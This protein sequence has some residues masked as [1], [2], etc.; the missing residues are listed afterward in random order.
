MNLTV[1]SLVQ[2]YLM[3]GH[4]HHSVEVW[5]VDKTMSHVRNDVFFK[6]GSIALFH[7]NQV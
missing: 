3:F 7:L 1:F 5:V 2:T 4:F 6:Y